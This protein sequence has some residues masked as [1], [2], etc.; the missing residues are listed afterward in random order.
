M[1]TV[2]VKTNAGLETLVWELIKTVENHPK[3]VEGETTE[4]HW[5]YLVCNG[6]T[7]SNPITLTK[8][9]QILDITDKTKSTHMGSVIQI[10]FDEIA[11]L[12]TNLEL[13]KV[14]LCV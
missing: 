2:H 14:N 13:T 11:I 9:A 4:T 3:Y 10:L 6:I 1:K 7:S 8:L 5:D 12:N